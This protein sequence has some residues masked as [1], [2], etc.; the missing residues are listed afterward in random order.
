MGEVAV[1]ITGLSRQSAGRVTGRL[2]TDG[3]YLCGKCGN[4][5]VAAAHNRT[6]SHGWTRT[7]TCKASKHL[8][9]NV[10]HLDAYIDEIV[11]GRLSQPDAA[12]V[13]SAL[14][15]EDV[16]ALHSQREGL[17][18]R[19]D[20]LSAMFADGDI[21]GPQLKRGSAQ[22]HA[23]LDRLEARLAT[24]RSASAVA[25]LVLTGDDLHA[26]WT[27]SPPDVR[28]K[29]HPRAHDGHQPHCSC[30]GNPVI[31]GLGSRRRVKRVRFPHVK[32]LA[33]MA[34]GVTCTDMW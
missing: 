26:T 30:R 17:R 33:G 14:A 28:G 22:L 19:L 31:G 6:T 21:D 16:G 29:V 23:Q 1:V 15:A 32:A 11:L 7:Y 4:T 20:D 34:G 9:R 12:I 2:R 10:E 13:L 5:M 25:N 24:A 8:G 27:A 3:V 18:A